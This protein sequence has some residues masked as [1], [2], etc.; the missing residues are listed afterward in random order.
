MSAQAP[1]ETSAPLHTTT[2]GQDTIPC[3]TR[4]SAPEHAAEPKRAQAQAC[5]G[6]L[7]VAGESD[8]DEGERLGT[9][10]HVV[11]GHVAGWHRRR[12][13]GEPRAPSVQQRLL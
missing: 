3:G 8:G 13:L 4:M 9:A 12:A 5:K 11:G 7:T 6:P 2:H 1:A 10:G